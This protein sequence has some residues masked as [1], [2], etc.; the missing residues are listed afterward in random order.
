MCCDDISKGGT[1]N[2]PCIQDAGNFCMAAVDADT[3]SKIFAFVVN[4]ISSKKKKR[5]K[6]QSSEHIVFNS[7]IFAWFVVV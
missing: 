4:S 6:K 2:L 3:C 5:R 1:K 7:S